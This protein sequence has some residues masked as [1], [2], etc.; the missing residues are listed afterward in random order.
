MKPNKKLLEDIAD[1]TTRAEALEK[2][3]RDLIERLAIVMRESI[4]PQVEP[5]L[6]EHYSISKEKSSVSM[7]GN[8]T[9]S[10]PAR[11]WLALELLYDGKPIPAGSHNQIGSVQR[12]LTPQLE[13]IA[14][15]YN[16]GEVMVYGEPGEI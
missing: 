9:D 4:I 1:Y 14:K 12:K 6:P 3:R 10:V 7:I 11:F 16:L 13:E 15:K 2:V 8:E 5:L